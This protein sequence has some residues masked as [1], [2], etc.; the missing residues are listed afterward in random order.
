MFEQDSK[1]YRRKKPHKPIRPKTAP[2]KVTR[3][4]VIVIE[5]TAAERRVIYGSTEDLI[6]KEL[7]LI[8]ENQRKTNIDLFHIKLDL[9]KIM[10]MIND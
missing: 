1:T 6:L 2:N 4:K 8:K 9:F 3:D 5:D 10:E 7:E